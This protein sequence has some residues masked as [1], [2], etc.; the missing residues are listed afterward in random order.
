MQ[1]NSGYSYHINTLAI[2]QM[3]WDEKLQTMKELWVSLSREESR[4]ESPSWHQ[5]ALKE[6]VARYD[7]GQEQPTDWAEAKLQLR[8]RAE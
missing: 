2:D 1:A 3:S 6:T 8:K 4:L 5:E 7:A